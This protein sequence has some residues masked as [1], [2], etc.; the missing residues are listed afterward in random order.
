MTGG[1][2]KDLNKIRGWLL[3][4]AVALV[5]HT[6]VAIFILTNSGLLAVATAEPM[7]MVNLVV[8]MVGGLSGLVLILTR[9]RVA[10]AFFTLYIPLLVVIVLL[11]PN[12]A[13][14][15]VAYGEALG[16][17]LGDPDIAVEI[18][19]SF[20][21]GLTLSITSTAL[22]FGYIL[23]SRRVKAVFGSTGLGL[24]RRDEIGQPRGDA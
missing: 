12:L 9:S 7:R 13:A 22:A 2:Q 15:R 4:F 8:Q 1:S 18:E 17:L 11:D 6:V 19:N 3:I 20:G 24:F 21:L 5:P 14:T 16:D 10:P 23:R